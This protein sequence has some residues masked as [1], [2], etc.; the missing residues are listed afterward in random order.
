[1]NTDCYLIAPTLFSTHQTAY[2]YIQ[3][4]EVVE[5]VGRFLYRDNARHSLMPRN[6]EP[7]STTTRNLLTFSQATMWHRSVQR[8]SGNI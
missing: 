6:L 1:M 7:P 3:A 4:A 2:D 5:N 8:C